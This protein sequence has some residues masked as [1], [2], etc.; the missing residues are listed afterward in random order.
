[1]ITI[2]NPFYRQDYFCLMML[3]VLFT[4]ELIEETFELDQN[5]T[6][7]LVT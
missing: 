2:S 3:S 1:M 7:N 6:E 4:D 5:K